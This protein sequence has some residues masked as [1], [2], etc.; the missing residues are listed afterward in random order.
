MQFT[1]RS[2]G[3]TSSLAAAVAFS[4]LPA[5]VAADGFMFVPEPWITIDSNGVSATITPTVSTT[6]GSTTIVSGP[7][8]SLTQTSVYT[9]SVFPED[10]S[11]AGP[12]SRGAIQDQLVNFILDFHIDNAFVYRD[13]IRENVLSKQYYCDVDIAHLIAYDEQLAHRLNN[14]PGDMIP[15]VRTSFK[16][17]RPPCRRLTTPSSRPPSNSAR[18]ASSTPHNATSSSP[19]T[20]C[21]CTRPSPRL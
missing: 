1:S 13:Q 17:L 20:S 5:L 7:P 3:F 2:G 9:L 15:L 21:C 14:E 11:Q 12:D 19:H 6:K 18:S 16:L 10:R 8:S 4:A